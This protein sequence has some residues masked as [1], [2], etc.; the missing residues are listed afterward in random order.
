MAGSF[1]HHS[2]VSIDTDDDAR[3][4]FA[5]FDGDSI[6]MRGT[7]EDVRTAQRQRKDNEPLL[8]VRRDDHAYVI[9][10]PMLLAR[11]K[12]IYAPIDALAK[13]QGKL[14]GKQGEL[15][16]RQGGLGAQQ[17]ELGRQ[18]AELDAQRAALEG[19]RDAD[20]RRASLDARQQSLEQRQAELGKRQE[21]LGQQ[22]EVL[23]RQQEMLSRKQQQAYEKA[24]QQMGELIDEAMAKGQAQAVPMR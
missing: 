2:H 20:Q 8:W 16:G 9:R 14:G 1:A 7:T 12:T 15:G 3:N 4:G 11:A 13:E 6:I 24:N 10:D 19:Q 22:Q 23:G 17:G 21:A 18:M 5:L